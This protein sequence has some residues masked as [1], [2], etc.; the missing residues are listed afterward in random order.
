M[1]S[2]AGR[3]FAVQLI[4]CLRGPHRKTRARSAGGS[5][6]GSPAKRTPPRAVNLGRGLVSPAMSGQRVDGPSENC[7]PN[8]RRRTL[9]PRT[10]GGLDSRAQWSAGSPSRSERSTRRQFSAVTTDRSTALAPRTVTLGRGWAGSRRRGRRG[11]HAGPPQNIVA[12]RRRRTM[13]V[14]LRLS[15]PDRPVPLQSNQHTLPPC[16]GPYR[17]YADGLVHVTLRAA[18]QPSSE[19]RRGTF[20]ILGGSSVG[21]EKRQP[22]STTE[23]EMI[24][25]LSPESCLRAAMTSTLAFPAF[26][27]NAG[28]ATTPTATS[29]SGRRTHHHIVPMA[30][31]GALGEDGHTRRAH[32]FCLHVAPP[33]SQRESASSH[34]PH[35]GMPDFL[36]RR[37]AL[38]RVQLPLPSAALCSQARR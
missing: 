13:I 28:H 10:V 14:L 21:G 26:A 3:R 22:T 24:A 30:Q 11:G 36:P 4:I 7:A 37:R 35:A 2:P 16:T 29:P 8:A 23:E 6:S 5:G 27:H 12:A 25:T 17:T 1:A 31:D 38:R 32:G 33:S 9:D 34:S 19:S 18:P 15:N 20:R